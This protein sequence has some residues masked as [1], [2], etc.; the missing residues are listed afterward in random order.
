MLPCVKDCT[1]SSVEQSCRCEQALVDDM[2]SNYCIHRPY[3]CVLANTMAHNINQLVSHHAV[4]IKHL[5]YLSGDQAPSK[6]NGRKRK[7][8]ASAN[9]LLIYNLYAV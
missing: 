4:V 7:D 3:H 9:I 8:R 2:Y 1:S 6:V 5:L